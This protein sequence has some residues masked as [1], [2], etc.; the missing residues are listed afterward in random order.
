MRNK[1]V[2]NDTT[3]PTEKVRK[4][5]PQA[6]VMMSKISIRIDIRVISKIPKKR[7]GP[8]RLSAQ[9]RIEIR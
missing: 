6:E 8:S 3:G 2:E 7:S 4:G 9:P 5:P 1:N